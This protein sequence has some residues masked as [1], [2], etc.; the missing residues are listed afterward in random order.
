MKNKISLFV[1][2]S[3]FVIASVLVILNPFGVK[4]L[5]AAVSWTE[6]FDTD[7]ND[8]VYNLTMTSGTGTGAQLTLSPFGTA[9]DGNVTISATK[10]INT[11]IISSGRVTYADGINYAVTGVWI[12]SITCSAAPNGIIAGDEIIIINQQGDSTNYGNVGNYEFFRIA[13][14]S[15]SFLIFT[16]SITK[17]YGATTSNNV[18]T[19]QKIT[20][21]RVPNWGNVTISGAAVSLTC[22]AWDGT[23]GG[24]VVFRSTG[25]VTVGSGASVDVSGKGYRGG[26]GGAGGPSNTSGGLGGQGGETIYGYMASAPAGNS[27][28]AGVGGLGHY[29]DGVVVGGTSLPTSSRANGWGAGGS[30]IDW[31]ILAGGGAGG[32]SD[33]QRTDFATDKICLGPGAGGGGGGAGG[34]RSFDASQGGTAGGGGG[35]AGGGIVKFFANSISL[36]GN[37]KADVGKGAGGG[38]SSPFYIAAPS[39]GA[40]G[41]G[42]TVGSGGVGTGGNGGNGNTG[43]GTGGTA[44]ADGD[45]PSPAGSGSGGNTNVS[46]GGNG[47][48]GDTGIYD[49]SGGGGAGASGGGGG[50]AGMDVGSAGGGGRGAGGGSIFL[51]AGSMSLGNYQVTVDSGVG[52]GGGGGSE[53]GAATAGNGGGPESSPSGKDSTNNAAG[54]GAQGARGAIGKIRLDYQSVTG[55]TNPAHYVGTFPSGFGNLGTY[56]SNVLDCAGS[57]IVSS[58]SWTP[59]NQPAGT[60]VTI[61][62]RASSASFTAGSFSPEW[63]GVANGGS[64]SITGRYVQYMSTYTTTVSTVTPRIEEITVY[65]AKAKPWQEKS[66]VRTGA[67]SYGIYGAESFVWEVPAKSGQLVTITAYIRYNTNYGAASKPKI[68]LYNLGISN[69]ATMSASSDTWE[70]LQVSG[71]PNRNGVL[72]LKIEGFSNAPGAKVYVDD[73][74][75]NQ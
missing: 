28:T 18:L 64:P 50:G 17:I 38:G 22:T 16:S 36:T 13:S 54:G 32:N 6:T 20:A 52:G 60:N 46:G 44:A 19:G 62:V 37:I 55:T 35:G 4:N 14:V 39:Q 26:N 10:N 69:T 33:I 24:M 72:E 5:Y 11:D 63:T 57:V 25:T 59:S 42:G 9:A 34:N 3:V 66:V 29:I 61:G 23:K 75:I 15:G 56:K 8:G 41:A 21:Q 53:G 67:N 31:G 45:Q 27:V 51:C 47:T 73:M 30:S 12:S 70:Q 43:T 49:A 71:T 68:T 74:I 58:V 1:I 65:Y 7:F 40:G 48:N 2:I